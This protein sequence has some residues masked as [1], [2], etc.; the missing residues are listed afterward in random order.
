MDEEKK[1]ENTIALLKECKR[2]G[3]KRIAIGVFD[4]ELPSSLSWRGP[5]AGNIFTDDCCDEDGNPLIWGVVKRLGLDYSVGNI[6]HHSAD[7]DS[8]ICGVYNIET[9]GDG[10]V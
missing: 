4:P 6:A 9:D 7:T 1:A 8:L 10:N 5:Y 3:I 2:V